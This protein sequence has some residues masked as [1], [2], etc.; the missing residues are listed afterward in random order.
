MNINTA[1][2]TGTVRT[3]WGIER[4]WPDGHVEYRRE[5]SRALAESSARIANGRYAD[6]TTVV[7]VTRTVTSMPWVAV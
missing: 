3:E 6:P 4:T 7:V 5:D 2:K 1:E